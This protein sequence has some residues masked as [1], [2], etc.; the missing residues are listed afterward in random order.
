MRSPSRRTSPT[1][2]RSRWTRWIAGHVAAGTLLL[3]AACSD[4]TLVGPAAR[5]SEPATPSVTRSADTAAAIVLA[6]AAI[7]GGALTNGANHTGQITLA[8]Q[9][10]SWTLT[11]TQGD[12]I[13]LSVG[14]VSGS[15]TF[16]PWVRLVAPDGTVIGNNWG[17][18]VGQVNAAA[19]STGTYTVL[20]ASADAARAGTGTY[21][22]TLA[23]GP[24]A[25]VVSAGDQ[26]GPLT[27]GAVHTGSIEVGDLDMWSFTAAQGESIVLSVGQATG[28]ANFTPW[29]RLVAPNGAVIGN[30]WGAAVGQVNVA[31]PST[32]TYTVIIGT[33]DAGRSE[34]GTYR[35]T[36]AKAPGAF[37]VSAGDQGG[38]M[39]NGAIHTGAIDVGDLDMWSFTATQG[40]ALVLS[41]GEV[42]GS[43]NFT[44]WIRLVAPNGA[45]IGNNWGA[46]VGQVNVAAPSTGTYTVIIGTADAGRSETGSYHLTLAK[47]PGAF[48]VSAGDQGGPLTN[49]AT[50]SG[51][52]DVGDLDVWSFAAAQGESLVLSVG[53]V[54]GSASFTPWIRLVAPN[55]AVI[56][57][58]WGAAVGQV[59][60]AAPSTGT[61]TVIIGS[62]DAARSG[63]G[64]YRLTLAKA[65]GAFT[66][67]VGD[68]GGALSNGGNH[69]GTIVVGDLDMWS[70]TAAQ[71][72]SIALSVGELTG[73]ANFTPWIRLVAPNGA[74]IGNNW[75]AAVGQVNVTAPSTGTY[76]VI[77]GTADAGRSETGT[78]RLT[79][80]KAPGAFVVAAGDQGGALLKGANL[81]TITIG[82]LD[83]WSFSTTQGSAIALNV[84]EVTGTASFTPWIR[85]VAPNGVV[86]GNVWGAASAQINLTATMTG[87]YTVIVGTADAGRSGT[88]DYRLTR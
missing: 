58:N 44:P 26:G 30:N 28:T 38:A 5:P 35:L 72:N 68:Q 71:G 49:G 12:A 88:G 18:A 76:T 81:G 62:A 22:L 3:A 42:S 4:A 52:I 34:T 65:P 24:G 15:T 13:S 74:V 54:T 8:G 87:T 79:L 23:K 6:Q 7:V 21:R 17:A 51:A 41:V 60:V 48:V 36:L 86:V 46:A 1:A 66:T 57:N 77:I 59:N 2:S 83:V 11:A 55:G 56:G 75:G 39:T 31:A 29:I 50:H 84:T 25:F 33:A 67:S 16:T 64:S 37:V 63:T 47:G 85:L 20:I 43:V 61:Y 80:A 32:G 45:V 78:Y 40:D 73:S 9:T 14:E 10:D 69:E 70:F 27:N 19:P 82:D 53:E